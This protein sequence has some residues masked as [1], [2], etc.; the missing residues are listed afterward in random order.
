MNSRASDRPV[1]FPWNTGFI[2]IFFPNAKRPDFLPLNAL[3]VF[4]QRNCEACAA[5]SVVA[6]EGFQAIARQQLKL[7]QQAFANTTEGINLSAASQPPELKTAKQADLTRKAYQQ[8][9]TNTREL[10]DAVLHAIRQPLD[11]LDRRFAESMEE[12]K[13]LANDQ[14][15]A[16]AISKQPELISKTYENAAADA[17]QLYEK[18]QETSAK[19]WDMLYKRLAEGIK[20]WNAEAGNWIAGADAPNAI[21]EIYQR[22]AAESGSLCDTMQKSNA[23]ALALMQ[24]RFSAVIGEMKTHLAPAGSPAEGIEQLE[25]AAHAYER[26]ASTIS[27]ALLRANNEAMGALQAWTA[28][29]MKAGTA[30]GPKAA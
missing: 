5:A 20:D 6:M 26:A 13:A 12:I 11:I 16:A 17:W 28:Q 4:Q 21:K 14:T 27:K 29:S 19:A 23:D 30:A 8:V 1:S 9:V 7:I 15:R 18:A 25:K 24:K 2:G 22:A 10:T 3:A